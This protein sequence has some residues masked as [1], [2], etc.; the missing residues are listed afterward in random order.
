VAPTVANRRSCGLLCVAAV[1]SGAAAGSGGGGQIGK[2]AVWIWRRGGQPMRERC[3]NATATGASTTVGVEANAG[4][5]Q[6]ESFDLLM[7]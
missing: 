3:P 6:T 1:C 4:G 5:D 7:T 2:V